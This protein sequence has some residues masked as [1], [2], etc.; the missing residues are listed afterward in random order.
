MPEMGPQNF[1]PL[2]TPWASRVVQGQRA[3]DAECGRLQEL[4]RAIQFTQSLVTE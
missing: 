4:V 3:L 1:L 2:K